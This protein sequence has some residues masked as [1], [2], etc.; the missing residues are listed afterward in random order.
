[1]AQQTI[2]LPFR[3]LSWDGGIDGRFFILDQ[4]RLP[5]EQVTIELDTVERVFEAIRTLAVRGAPALGAA[6]AYGL[7]LAARTGRNAAEVREA[8]SRGKAFLAGSRPTAHNLFWALDRVAAAQENLQADREGLLEALLAAARRI[9][10]E[11]RSACERIGR[12]ALALLPDPIRAMTHCNAGALATCGIGTALAPFYAARAAG[13]DVA[14][15]ARETRPLL[16]GARLTAWELDRAGIPVTVI[17]DGAAA[18]ILKLGRVNCVIVGADRIARNGDAANK[19]GTYGLALAAARHG[20]P[21]YVAAPMSTFDLAVPHGDAIAIEERSPREVAEFF[22]K[23]PVA[24]EG[25]AC[26]NPAF[27]VTPADLITALI[28]E[29]GVAQPP[30]EETISSVLQDRSL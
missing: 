30:T 9:E 5:H 4:R 25:I 16:Q 7:V 3:T 11:D 22:D 12:H 29:R 8:L 13:R 18:H 19:I 26:A 2:S 1:M 10:E 6:A 24:P 20:V 21:F 23:G 28:T 14:V 15:Y 27:D 17:A